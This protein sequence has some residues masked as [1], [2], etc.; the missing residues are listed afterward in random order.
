MAVIESLELGQ[1]CIQI[2]GRPEQGLVEVLAAKRPNQPLYERMR[3][4][5]VWDSLDLHHLEYS[6][7]GF[8]L[9]EPIQRIMI[10]AEVFGQTLSPNRA[11]E[12]AAERHSVHGTA[13]DAKPDDATRELVHHNE[14]PVGPQG[15][16]FASE[17]IA[18]P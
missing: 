12:H 8:P 13:V 4:R 2:D 1:F 11:M 16:G 3:Q 14:N 7:I 17:Q 10:R 6:K 18:T 15:G 9:V 5:H